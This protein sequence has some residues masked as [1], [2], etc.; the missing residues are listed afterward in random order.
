MLNYKPIETHSCC[1]AGSAHTVLGCY[2]SKELGKTEML[3]KTSHHVPLAT[4]TNVH[5]D[6]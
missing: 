4:I 5:S 1:F 2:W 6:H 3:G